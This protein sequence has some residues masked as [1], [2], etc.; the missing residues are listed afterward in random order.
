MLLVGHFRPPWEKAVS[1]IEIHDGH[2]QLHGCDPQR[3]YR[4]LFL[5]TPE[6]PQFFLTA[7]GVGS[8]GGLKVPQLMGPKVKFGASLEVSAKTAR[9]EPLEVRLKRTGSA[10][11]RILDAKGL[12]VGGYE[13][14]LELVVSPG[15]TFAAAI[16]KGTMAAES[17]YL[18]TN[19][20]EAGKKPSDPAGTLTVY[21]L[22]P[23]ATYRVRQFQQPKVLKDFTAESGKTIDVDVPLQ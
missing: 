7:K 8:N 19:Y 18:A 14:S 12:L 13:P 22:I 23:G 15:P 3:T 9:K 17:V 5:A 11:L 10:H 20:A 16:E 21:G 4:L 2:W 1:P 6:K